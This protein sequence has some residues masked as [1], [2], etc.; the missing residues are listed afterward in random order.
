MKRK[1]SVL[2]A[3]VMI[4]TLIPMSSF[5]QQNFDK[6]LKEAITKSKELFNIGKE[7]DKFSSDVSSYDGK[8]AFNLNWS[9][10]KEKLGSINVSLT[11]DGEIL[12]YS[13]SEPYYGENRPK[14]P[15]VSKDEGLKIAKDFIGKVSP[16][17][18]KNIKYIDRDEQLDIYS[19]LYN[20]SFIRT[21][22]GMIY[23]E[24]NVNIT[25]DNITGEVRDYY[26]NW[27]KDIVFSE[28]KDVISKEKAQE[29]Y[30]QK[31]GLKLIYKTSYIEREPRLYLTYASLRN[32]L[33]IDAKNGEAVQIGY[34]GPYYEGMDMNMG[35]KGEE[36]AENLSPD[37]QE[38]VESVSGLISEEEAEK[39]GRKYLEINKDYKLDSVNLYRDWKNKGEYKWYLGFRKNVNGVEKYSSVA[40]NAKSKELISFYRWDDVNSNKEIK[41]NE[42][43]ALDIAKNFIVKTNPEKVNN[44]EYIDPV[45]DSR[46]VDE[47]PQKIVNLNFMRIENGAYVLDD[48]IRV[49]VDLTEGKIV[50]YEMDWYNGK[51]PSKDKVISIDE[52]YNIL[53]DQ[54]GMEVRY[55]VPNRYEKTDNKKLEAILVYGLKKDKP[56]DIDANTGKILNYEG[57][58]YEKREKISYKDIEKSYAKDKINILTQYGIGFSGNEFKPSEK[59]NQRDFLFLLAKAN[60]SY[61]SSDISNN[62]EKLYSYLINTGIV[63]DD[64]KAP[65]KIMT[66]EEAIKYIIRALKYDKVA[67]LNNIYKDLFK[68]TKDINPELKGYVSIAY[69]LKI[70]EGSNGYL[71]PKAELKREDGANLIYNFLFSN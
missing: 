14:L 51:L 5:A 32:N 4:L 24:N 15:K 47:V 3:I 8:T 59:L 58:P 22:N 48:A 25:V 56:N 68:D 18:A 69:G 34:Y 16:D 36:N 11:V 29:L 19:D 26:T 20:Y 23:D 6:Q 39:L 45:A 52:A 10:S 44:I 50:E 37:E 66:K 30:K 9:D 65:K 33:G 27:D 31:I 64:E 62:D 2:L 61:L 70:V 63:K 55:T 41:Y 13:K 57:I 46:R 53:F 35:A 71:R 28:A 54:I 40:V 7:Y 49:S 67:D 43:Q 42:K 38:A 60:N 12:S 21:I 17:I 1:V